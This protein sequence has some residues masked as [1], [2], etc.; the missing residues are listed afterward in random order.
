MSEHELHPEAT[1]TRSQIEEITGVPA[2]RSLVEIR[3][4]RLRASTY[5][6]RTFRIRWA[7]FVEWQEQ[8]RVEP[9]LEMGG[10]EKIKQRVTRNVDK[11]LRHEASLE[12]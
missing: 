11:Q 3:K 8:T 5:G 6:G 12:G 10:C 4:G 7:D 2:K 9:R 1:F